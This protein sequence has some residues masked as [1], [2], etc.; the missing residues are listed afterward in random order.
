[1]I[2]RRNVEAHRRATTLAMACS[3]LFLIGYVAYHVT[4]DHTKFGGAGPIRYVYYFLLVTHI[5]FAAASLPFIL[6]AWI[7]GVTNQF[8]KHRRLVKW[9]FPMWLY[10]ALTGPICYLLLRPYY[11]Q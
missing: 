1:M 8:A 3:V 4:S 11:P 2:K 9:V 7:Y 5:I 10:V 6:Y